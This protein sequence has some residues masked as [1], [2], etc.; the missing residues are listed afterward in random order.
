MT[1]FITVA[2]I[3]ICLIAFYVFCIKTG[4]EHDEQTNRYYR[5]SKKSDNPKR[6][7]CP[8]CKKEMP[9]NVYGLPNDDYLLRPLIHSTRGNK[10]YHGVYCWFHG[11]VWFDLWNKE[12]L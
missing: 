9:K 11:A 7:V 1:I 5:Y 12:D 3:I 8:E 2:I 6:A 10:K 4:E